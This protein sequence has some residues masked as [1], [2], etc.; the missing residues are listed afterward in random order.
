M[1]ARQGSRPRRRLHAFALLAVFA[2]GVAMGAPVDFDRRIAELRAALAESGD[3]PA[4]ARRHFLQ[5]QLLTSIERRRDLDRLGAEGRAAPAAASGDE[6]P[7]G[8]LA[9]DDLRQ[10]KQQAEATVASGARRLDL[11]RADRQAA[12]A[13]LARSV[14]QLRQAEAGDAESTTLA[15]LETELAE[16]TTAELDAFLGVIEKQQQAAQAQLDTLAARLAR[17]P[18]LGRPGDADIAALN[19]RLAAQ[20][21]R[22]QAR[23]GTASV[24]RDAARTALNEARDVDAEQRR[25]LAEQLATRDFAV[26]LAR[27]AWANHATEEAAWR[28]ALSYWVDNDANAPVAARQRAPQLKDALTRRLDYLRSVADL[29]LGQIGALDTRAA[30]A[31]ARFAEALRA[32][33]AALEQ[34]L[35]GVQM[36]MIDQRGL[37]AL[38]ERL[39]ADFEQRG[40]QAGWDDRLALAWASLRAAVLQAWNLELF[41]IDETVEVDGRKTS[42]PRGVTVAKL[43]KAPLLLL[44]GLFLAARLTAWAE[45]RARRRGVDEARARLVRRWTRG[46]LALACLLLS[47]VLAG[48]PF[49]AFAFAGGALA[50]GIGFGM[51]T[52]LKNLISGMIVLI[53]RPF[54]LGDQIDIGGLR[55][56]VVDI[57]LRTS[58]VRDSDGS[59][60][61]VPNSALIDNNVRNYTFR[62]RVSRQSFSVTVAPGSDTRD[63][64]EAMRDAAQRHGQLVATKEPQVY[65]D[66]IT[67]D[68]LRFTLQY[69]IELGSDVDR[70]RIASDLRLMV[71]GAFADAGVRLAESAPDIRRLRELPIEATR[72]SSR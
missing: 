28:L 3:A 11:L 19:A 45:R 52:L 17:A 13:Q 4:L 14:A 72:T 20:R 15:R 41:A 5:R 71:L 30:H 21:E 25:A 32:Q 39:R 43:I 29:V 66:D 57:S 56:T 2:S 23:L 59:E 8:L 9:L 68:G 31:D 58:A 26:E 55:G 10:A 7:Q 22:L 36:A 70:G 1:T 65:L 40:E 18:S 48:I 12:A 64:A 46:L 16:S 35:A 53:E 37:I 27:E 50:I 51:Q 61:L 24:A 38:I 44:A 69:W 42:V 67:T 62:T 63:V 47:L 54:R 33:R 6:V 34:R 49:A 60:T